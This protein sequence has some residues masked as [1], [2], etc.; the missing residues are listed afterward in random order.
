M[1][2]EP[3]Q[4]VSINGIEFDALIDQSVSYS[5]QV[6]EYPTEKGF[7]VSDTIILKNEEVS[8]TLYVT[9]TPVTWKKR[10]GTTSFGRV[11]EVVKKLEALYFSKQLVTVVTSNAVYKNMA[12]TSYSISK[13]ADVGYAR[14]IPVTFQKVI[15][16]E[17]KKVTIPD[18]YGK[19]GATG[20]SAGTA[21]TS[22]ASS[23]SSS[24]SSNSKNGSIAYNA[25]KSAGLI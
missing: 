16:T 1:A 13:S 21:N 11:D 23:S 14:E 22:T 5:A 12:L 19:S 4:P 17:T 18:S 24:D 2:R 20:A 3:K 9:D 15:T 10:F 8:M 6:P 7:N 25:A